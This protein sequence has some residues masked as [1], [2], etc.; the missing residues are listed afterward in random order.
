MRFT[1]AIRLDGRGG[2]ACGT[3]ISVCAGQEGRRQECLR[4]TRPW[5]ILAILLA[6]ALAASARAS[7]LARAD[8]AI[9][10]I[11]LEVDTKQVTTGV[12]I[13]AYIQTIFGGKQNEQALPVP[14]LTV[15]GDLTGPGIES[16]I[17]LFTQPGQKFAL[18]GLHEKGEYALQNIRLLT[19]SGQFVQQ[20]VP[21]F[22]TIVVVEVMSTQVTVRQLS[23]DELRAR[24]ITVDPRNYEVWS[25]SIVLSLGPGQSVTIPYDVIVSRTTHEIIV[26]PAPNAYPLPVLTS[27]NIPPRFQPPSTYPVF[28]ADEPEDVPFTP[29]AP[30][31]EKD[32]TP[33]KPSIPAAIVIPT[34]FGVLHDFFLVVLQ[35]S[36]VAPPDSEIRLDSISATL[37]APLTLRVAK[38]TPA[39]GIG[40]PLPIVDKTTGTTFLVAGAQ[41]TGD[42]TLE[43]LKAGTH[44]IDVD[45]R[46]TYKAPN[47][48][49]VRLHG[50]ASSSIV[51]SDPRFHIAFSHPDV[52]RKDE[53]YT[54]YAFITNLSPQ[55]RSLRIDTAEIAQCGQGYTSGVC[56]TE[57]TPVAELTL[58]PGEMKSLPYKLKAGIDGHIFAAAGAASDAAAAIEVKLTMG[59]SASGIPL[60]PAT[61]VMPWYARYLDSSFVDANLSLLGLGYSLATAPLTTATAKFPRVIRT[62]VFRRAQDLTRAGQ[63]IFVSRQDVNA[64]DPAENRD[65]LFNLALDLLDNA[66]RIDRLTPELA[67][68]D[69][70]R[71]SEENGRKAAAAMARQVEVNGLPS[72]KSISQF[73]DD[74]AA[75]TCHRSHYFLAVVHAPPVSGIERP[76]ALSLTSATTA[77]RLDVPAEAPGGWIRGMPFAELTRLASSTE[78]GEM[79][80]V[81]RW[82][83]DL[84]LSVVPQSDR[85]TIDLVWPDTAAGAFLRSTFEVT[86]AKPGSPVA[87]TV[88]RG[89]RTL[90]VSGGTAAPLVNPVAQ[91]PL[92]AIAAAQD[93]HLDDAGHV[94]SLPF[95]RPVTVSDAAK[96]RDAFGLTTKIDSIAY[97]VT[98]RNSASQTFIPGAS[99][100]D[101]GSIVNISFD[102]ALSTNASYAIAADAIT[103]AVTGTASTFSGIVPRVD[104]KRPGGILFGRL[105]RADNSVVP[106]TPVQLISGTSYQYDTTTDQGA[107]LFEFIPRD[108]DAGQTG[109][110]LLS[111]SAEGKYT[112]ARGT[113]RLPGQVQ[114]V[115]LMFLGRGTATG[116]VRTSDGA[117]VANTSV[118]VSSPVFQEFRR[119]TTDVSGRYSI[120]DLPVGPLTFIVTDAAGRTAY[121]TNQIRIAG[122]TVTQ[123]LVIQLSDFPGTASVRVTVRRSDETDPA[124]SLV[125]NAHVGVWS[126]GYGVVDATTDAGGRAEFSRVPA[127]FISIL[128]SEFN[129]TSESAAIDLDVKPDAV[130]DQVIVL[131]VPTKTEA[132]ATVTLEGSI[133]RDDPVAMND[134]SKDQP[135]PGAVLTIVGL[136]PTTAGADGKYV[137]PA[138]P[139][140]FGAVKSMQVFDPSTGRRGTF[141]LP[142]LVP[143]SNPFSVRLRSSE[144]AG[145]AT[146]R[147]R[148]TGA[149][150]EPVTGYRVLAAYYPPVDFDEVTPGVY[151]LAKV[152]VPQ[153]YDV[154]AVP[155]D[156]KSPYGEQSA[157]GSVRVDF[158]GQIGVADL[159][160]PGQGTVVAKIEVAQPCG[161]PPC[162][163]PATG[164]VNLTYMSWD[165]SELSAVMTEHR[166]EPDP[167]TGYVTALRIPAGKDIVAATIDHPAGYASASTRLGY[168]GDSQTV[169]L[170]LSA[171]TEVRG[172]LFNFDGQTPVAGA[173]VRLE[174][175]AANILPVTTDAA[176]A[177][178]FDGVAANQSFRVIAE[179]SQDGI[180]RTGFVDS[181]TPQ[182]G[183]LVENLAVVL[184]EQ[185]SVEGRVVDGG[186]IP[187]PLAK[188]WLRE[189]AWPYRTFGSPADP[190][191]ADKTGHFAV[192]NV[193]TGGFRITAVSPDVQELRGDLQGE[194][195]FEGDTSQQNLVV[196]IGG[197]GTGSVSVAVVDPQNA[198]AR[199]PNAEVSLIRNGS[200]FDFTTTDGNG[201]TLFDEV[202][203]AGTYSVRA[204]SK[205]LGATGTGADFAVVRD[206]PSNVTVTL[207]IRGKVSG[208]VRDPEGVPAEAPVKGAPVTLRQMS[209]TTRA[210]TDANGAFV[211]DGVP[212]GNFTVDAF[213]IESGRGSD[214]QSSF[215]SKLYP[216]RSGLALELE[217]M[218]SLNVKVFLPDDAGH[219]GALAPLTDIKVT[220]GGAYL[221]QLQGNDLTFR[222]LF[223]KRGW[224][225]E[226]KELGG[227][228][229]VAAAGGAFPANSLEAA[230]NLVF[231]TFG[232]VQ[233]AVR[234]ASNAPVADA[235]V[236]IVGSN[237]SATLNTGAAGLVSF[238]G[239]A[240]G[241][242]SVRAAKGSVAASASGTLGSHAVPL[243]FTLNLGA[244]AS[245][246]GGV[247]AE[248]GGPSAGTRVI[249]RA[250]SRL[251]TSV[252]QLETRT[253]ANGSWR[254][255]AIPIG[256]T[257]VTLKCLAPDDT[258]TGA[259][260]SRSIP[261][262]SSGVLDLGRVRL[263][264]TPPRVVSI[265]PP[266]NAN[267]VAP[268][269]TVAVTLS[270]SVAAAF[271]NAN[272]FQLISTDDGQPVPSTAISAE[273]AADGALL[274]RI[275]APDP[276]AAQI[277]A[278]Q[279]YRLKSNVIYR[280][281]VAAG[282][283]DGS[284]NAMPSTVGSTF[285]T[286]NYTEPVITSIAPP[287]ELPL[288]Q[289]TTFRVKFNKAVDATS[290]ATGNGGVLTLERLASY[291]GLPIAVVEVTSYRDAVDAA[292]LVVAPRSVIAESAYYRL[293]IAGTRD[294]QS[295]P[296]VQA[297]ARTFD[298]FSFDLKKPVVAISS[299]VP[300]GY[301]LIAGVA[302]SVTPTITDE[303]T[304]VA[305]TDTAY[306]DWLDEAG[307]FITRSRVSPYAYT[308]VAPPA[309]G[310]PALF[311]LKA[312]AT[313]LSGNTSASPAAR[314]WNVAP[315]DPPKDL[316]LT[317]DVASAYP[318]RSVTA[319][320]LFSDEG[321]SVTVA[322]RLTGTHRDGSAYAIDLGSTR[323]TRT[324]VADV[325]PSAT[326]TFIVPNAL[327]EGTATLTA[328]ATDSAN[329]AATVTAAIEV[330]ADSNAPAVASLL[331]K[332]E[333]HYRNGQ[334]LT[335]E[336]RAMDA[337]T[338]VARAVITIGSGIPVTILAGAAGST[339]DALSGIWTFRTSITVPARNADTRVHIAVRVFDYRDNAA[340]ASTDVI[341]DRVDDPAIPNAS[342]ITPVDGAALPA[343][344]S[345]WLTT[346]RVRARG[347]ITQV[348]FSSSA[349]AAAVT[350]TAPKS[351]TTDVFESKVALTMPADN[352]PFV[353]TATISDG[354]DA[355]LVELPI[356]VDP[357][358]PD[359]SVISNDL[360]I[361]S[362][363]AADYANKSFLLRGPAARL[364]VYVPLALKNLMLIDG[365][366]VS[367]PTQTKLDLTIADRLFVD[368]DSSIDL[369]ARGYLGGWATRDDGGGRNESPR[370]QTAGGTTTG[371]AAASASY[372]GSGG[373]SP[374]DATNAPYGSITE[375]VDLGS[376]GGGSAACCTAGG[377]GG[378]AIA[379]RGGS[380]A[381]ELSRF[382]I[383][384]AIRADGQSGVNRGAAGSGGSLLVS[385]HALIAGAAASISAS[386]GDDDGA[387]NESRGGGGGRVSVIVG[388]RFDH[389]DLALLLQARG[390]RNG[391]AS[392]GATFTDGGAGTVFLRRAGEAFGELIVSSF[393]ARYP[394]SSHATR[395]TTLA[396]G[397]TFDS[398][399][400]GPRALA[401]FDAPYTVADPAKVTVDPTALLLRPSDQ[402]A[403]NV[404]ATTPV[405]PNLIQA[406]TLTATFDAAAA[407]G[408]DHVRMILSAATADAVESFGNHPNALTSKQLTS[409]IPDT[410][411]PGGATMRLRAVTRSGRTVETTPVAFTVVANTPPSIAQFDVVP[412]ASMYAGH[413]IVAA[414]KATDDIEV[415]SMTLTS[416]AGTV[417]STPPVLEP[418]ANEL[419]QQFAVAIPAATPS[420][421]TVQLTL[422]VS[423]G[424]PN[425]AAVTRTGSVSI[426]KDP[427]P[428]SIAISKP[429][430][431]QIF[432][433]GAGN[434]IAV[435][436]TVTDAEVAVAR[437][438]A[439]IDG[440]SY[441]LAPASGRP[442]VFTTT[443]PVPN[444]DGTDLVSKTLTFAAIDYEGNQKISEAVTIEVRP[445][446]DPN[447]PALAWTCGTPGAIVP[448]GGSAKLRVYAKGNTVA[449]GVA[450]VEFFVG[451]PATVIAATAVSGV[452]DNYEATCTVPSA[453]DG[454]T[455]PIRAVATSVAG[456]AADIVSTLTLYNGAMF[457]AS[458]TIAAADAQYDGHAI[459][460]NGSGVV[461]T[462][463]GHHSFTFVAALDGAMITH[464]PTTPAAI[465]RLDLA[466]QAIYVSCD[467]SIDVSGRG[468]AGQVS[469]W[470]YTYKDP[471]SGTTTGGSYFLAGG[472]HG[473][474]GGWMYAQ[475]VVALPFGSLFDANEP[476]GSG[477][478]QTMSSDAY[479][480]GGGIVR[481]VAGTLTLDGR[482]DASGRTD[483][484]T[485]TAGGAGGGIHIDVAALNGTGTIRADGGPENGG[486]GG[487]GRIVID[488]EAMSL[489]RA[490]VTAAGG[491]AGTV[492]QRGAVGTIYLKGASQANGDLIIDNVTTPVPRATILPAAGMGT[493]TSVNSSTGGVPDRIT[494]S[495]ASFPSP[496]MLAGH[497]LFFA[498]D[499]SKT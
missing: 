189:L 145:T 55:S 228:G 19:S 408:I 227:E 158:D 383:A 27:N 304:L 444:V 21:S 181:R 63:R 281:V 146:M 359:L 372:G 392:E 470:G 96:L 299:P 334:T 319:R 434:T 236:T 69:Q 75:A 26:P 437:A 83:E 139:P 262:G 207:E 382:A 133:T 41:G 210:S 225:V 308:F 459:F 105:L 206:V 238:D 389:D 410:A 284:A 478:R 484:V 123:D 261:D 316:E 52:I 393:D 185:S 144:P 391:G 340:D 428:P 203:A 333:T 187:V 358:T 56:R 74:F 332:A 135:V 197:S 5:A 107:F 34:G 375:P 458:T 232:T 477:G 125:P 163:A 430:A 110:Y 95:N 463:A 202:P 499:R 195:R 325:W 57:G 115:N 331:P 178:H 257:F 278:G 475:D 155:R 426:L 377:S 431:G 211:F 177:F 303:G 491:T 161:T 222:K 457:S 337:D 464:P 100:Q 275:T 440:K 103:D 467:S 474:A 191:L 77:T 266:N 108:I 376:G 253:D 414:A 314:T 327:K 137:Y 176:G 104:N 179:A 35:I 379:L 352:A 102:K 223:A 338:G 296:N 451:D 1:A 174:A 258:T 235:T 59:V 93:L 302:Y 164:P 196:A 417:T 184:R 420:G 255:D 295:P 209:L 401:R 18:P 436:A 113:I 366:V 31:A 72:G 194:I 349:M 148:L 219:A 415:K 51:V 79:A 140:S 231:P 153:G 492:K 132:T 251:L 249:L 263:D 60:S 33:K 268:N 388:D 435:E 306:V 81:G 346:L 17:A 116:T 309:S 288:P 472:S 370:G 204:Y 312:S 469:G 90:V 449:N 24:G 390:G 406:S 37:D 293:T 152:S 356:T 87:V 47:Q 212:E 112:E 267:N 361:T 154:W 172:R 329:K 362:S 310:T 277:A 199:V 347:N 322:L 397:L 162:Y 86:G 400:I 380:G 453:S 213:E 121:A 28:L 320:V 53:P 462:I 229:R 461:L 16:P 330:L 23:A 216:E 188:Y 407:D 129:L 114:T 25:Y 234:D 345:G 88:A 252:L 465:Q 109:N 387:D 208:V 58:A 43:A 173:S 269:S 323:I 171:M 300:D 193:F 122:E 271:L 429:A 384:G 215:I 483:K 315:N 68:W 8:L 85:F 286:T 64:A 20:A 395:G 182:S 446:I 237:R 354:V 427:N 292:T 399:S 405:G 321:L 70:L 445:L 32:Q 411:L 343:G 44:T 80:L 94:V 425:R 313:D 324:T 363:N 220:Q 97:Q 165:E 466:A 12:D 30:F 166:L 111:A 45:I 180:Y 454:T 480:P 92:R 490:N 396:D 489:P 128:A 307:A 2:V 270:E 422:A 11:S 365:A 447:A 151:E 294:T 371:G 482:I 147:V 285:T 433:E 170:R 404:T 250:T 67:E 264:A 159:H 398:I 190:L 254:F 496:N 10:G 487:G 175:A 230:V 402:P 367:N 217:R 130:V 350:L 357:L 438:W 473:G 15:A 328:T 245:I 385:A 494:D 305:S 360:A 497:R 280:V 291:K 364:F 311:T 386:G 368:A 468:F 221:R 493:I 233:V 239:F 3:D 78:S 138:V 448:A 76:L 246:T 243:V 7:E 136:A 442:D 381:S 50:K 450:K 38:A 4:H 160:L 283:Q 476:G 439:T 289:Q 498:G 455:V 355:H 119:G 169:T 142:T 141:V 351:G 66:E 301:P 61:L 214:R 198:F 341:Y 224:T 260:I 192:G 423:D 89:S 156:A 456:N 186:G 149:R 46:A 273:G 413:S 14:D 282:I 65:P 369:T 29:S 126:R 274:V 134:L 118:T 488:Y 241:T 150:G 54:A 479:S 421:T 342:W 344:Q 98:R 326:F 409:S 13:G 256:D 9:A 22:A 39:I 183:G 279:K 353:I 317:T 120:S 242:I 200:G 486:A 481:L 287:V 335:V 127:G 40:Q 272:Y 240:L 495:A 318:Q 131:H 106:S 443:V 485:G 247:D 91:T 82:K 157:R 339:F 168:D 259:S 441:D 416:T 49:D 418:A 48:A 244:N 248:G 205:I 276:T 71:R 412:A 432:D 99:L 403:L 374:A 36:N 6:I 378:G 143:G 460:A 218:A 117:V 73:V 167:A 419:S 124:K 348:V 298:Y 42:W 226:A 336:L 394:Q 101:D 62:D 424:F 373:E 84:Q 265:D 297:A 201:L 290:F 452:A 471:T